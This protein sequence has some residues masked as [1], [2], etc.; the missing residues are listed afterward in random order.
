LQAATHL[1]RAV[2][3]RPEFP[4]AHFNLAIALV[5][6]GRT[7]DGLGALR[8]G[9]ELDGTQ[10]QPAISVAW[11][12]A[13]HPVDSIRDPV[14]ATT[15]ALQVRQATGPHAVVSDVTAAAF[16]ANADFVNARRFIDEAIAAAEIAGDVE[17]LAELRARRALYLAGRSYIASGSR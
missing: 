4:G 10:I 7:D 16:A 13:T 3:L 6:I 14:A 2:R 11:I 17:L 9:V 1:E 12:L 15:I 8:R 5:S